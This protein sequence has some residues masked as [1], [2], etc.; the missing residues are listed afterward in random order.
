MRQVLFFL[1]LLLTSC[2]SIVII[3]DPLTSEEHINLGYIYERQG[4]YELAEKEYKKAIKKDRKNWLAYYNL[5]NIYAK[6]EKWDIA[7]EFYL[8]ALEFS[9][10]PDLL[11]NLAY[12]L[13]KKG[14]HCE[15]LKLVKEALQKE[16]K[17]EYFQTMK[18]IEEA[19]KRKGIDCLS[20]KGKGELW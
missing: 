10:D 14:E 7:E 13:N 12:V 4:K 9:K 2:S 1:T 8:K 17:A 20:F 15:A 5:G 19:I 11:N 18:E 3:K 16:Q 6:R